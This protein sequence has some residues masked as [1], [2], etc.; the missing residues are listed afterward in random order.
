MRLRR[1]TRNEGKSSEMTTLEI[2]NKTNP[3][4]IRHIGNVLGKFEMDYL[5]ETCI[6][7]T[8]HQNILPQKWECFV[9]D[10]N[11]NGSLD[12]KIKKIF[13]KKS[14]HRLINFS[15]QLYLKIK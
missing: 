8:I 9:K 13:T 7:I 4:C 3:N 10:N 11:H 2:T 6:H 1:T 14:N 12:D 15:L 5:Q